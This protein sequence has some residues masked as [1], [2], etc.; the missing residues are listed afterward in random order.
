[1]LLILVQWRVPL[2]LLHRSRERHNGFHVQLNDACVKGLPLL[3]HPVSLLNGTL[4]L[5]LPQGGECCCIRRPLA[6]AC[7][8]ESTTKS[9]QNAANRRGKASDQRGY[10]LIHPSRI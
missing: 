6:C 10:P 7:A 8:D 9:A 2:K 5:H 3:P 4:I 1:L